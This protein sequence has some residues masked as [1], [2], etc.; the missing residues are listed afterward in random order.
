MTASSLYT[1]FSL[2]SF[3]EE[4]GKWQN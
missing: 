2:K 1:L 4:G 3:A